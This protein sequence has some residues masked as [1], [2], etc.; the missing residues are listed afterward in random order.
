[1][2]WKSHIGR[3]ERTQ[4][5]GVWNVR[6]QEE[7]IWPHVLVPYWVPIESDTFGGTTSE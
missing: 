1:M 6:G 5:R 3:S 4:N 7:R 2:D